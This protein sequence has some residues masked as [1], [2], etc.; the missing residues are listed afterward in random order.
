MNNYSALFYYLDN[1]NIFLI[2][3]IYP[4]PYDLVFRL[5]FFHL[6]NLYNRNNHK[7]G[8]LSHYNLNWHIFLLINLQKMLNLHYYYYLN[9]SYLL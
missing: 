3:G 4:H 6:N 7:K 9:Y 5:Y 8:I 2:L 1:L